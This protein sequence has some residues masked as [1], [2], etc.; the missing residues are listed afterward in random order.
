MVERI[1]KEDELIKMAQF[2]LRDTGPEMI[3]GKEGLES[4]VQ[5]RATSFYN[6][7]FEHGSICQERLNSS[8]AI[9]FKIGGPHFNGR[10]TQVFLQ[11]FIRKS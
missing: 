9:A 2:S 3:P 6:L 8:Y 4:A 1:E 11:P 10:E 7:M 5:E